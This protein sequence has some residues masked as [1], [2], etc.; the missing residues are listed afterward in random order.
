MGGCVTNS[1]D[2]LDLELSYRDLAEVLPSMV[3]VSRPD[4]WLVYMNEHW[5]AYTGLTLRELNADRAQIFH[6]DDAERVIAANAAARERGEPF[7]IDY[8]VR[9]HDGVYRWHTW[10][11]VPFRD[12]AGDISHWAGATIDID[13]RRRSEQRLRESEMRWLSLAETMPANVTL[14]DP[15]GRM[16]YINQ[17]W[18]DFMGIHEMR[19]ATREW[20]LRL[21]PE[22]RE[23]M[24]GDFIKAV[25][26]NQP[27]EGETRVRGADG[28]YRWF[29]GRTAPVFSDDGDVIWWIGVSVDISERRAHEEQAHARELEYR[30]LADATPAIVCRATADGTLDYFNSQWYAYTGMTP[31]GAV[32]AR[33]IFH[34]DEAD[35]VAGQWWDAIRTGEPYDIE[36]RVRR[37][38]GMYRWHFGRVVPIRDAA[39]GIVNWLSS[40]V[41]IDERKRAED[42]QRVLNEI[43]GALSRSLNYEATLDAIVR[44]SAP[45]FA[46][47]CAVYMGDDAGTI[48]RIATGYGDPKRAGL[49]RHELNAA[50]RLGAASVISTGAVQF[51]ERIPDEV[52]RDAATSDE[53]LA[54]LR[55]VG[56]RSGIVVPV[57]ARGSII[58][59][60]SFSTAESCR[61]YDWNDVELA[62]E[63]GRRAG[64]AIDNA[65]LY[66][67]AQVTLAE[68]RHAN[69][70]KDEFLGLVSHELKTPITTILGNA[71][72]LH[73]KRDRISEGDQ[74]MALADIAHEAERLH[75]II[76]NLL[77]LARLERGQHIEME[78]LLIER[79]V[80]R[81]VRDHMRTNPARKI[82]IT[83]DAANAPALA[84][85]GYSE[86]VLRNL[87]S[88]AE[89][90]SPRDQP[91]DVAITLSGPTIKI[92]VRDRGEGL[93]ADEAE[94]IF[95]P[96]YRSPRVADRAQGVGIGLSVCRRLVEA[97][98]GRIAAGPA[99][100]G[101][102]EFWFT[103]PLGEDHPAV[104]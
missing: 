40:S 92:S 58:G 27:F 36:Y 35:F 90:Y 55:A 28:V 91:I 13:D 14:A 79:F 38:D 103:L 29:L 88:N 73:D 75:S 44:A 63:I 3:A 104:E 68:L 70:A 19:E 42:G 85:A 77:V 39:G 21:H 93:D 97:Q 4:G 96:F 89:K 43:G 51:W 71:K 60:M 69:D 65:R 48:S 86:Q 1:T 10:R 101:G 56:S 87:L 16:Q 11:C 5:R 62:V 7:E 45:R 22:D 80:E 102:T 53:H 34:P 9:R 84:E 76:E 30:S 25:S 2:L 100:G 49:V 15:T 50:G 72:V 57:V 94:R 52:L 47:F 33:D 26:A 59:A 74:H 12:A 54:A 66:R 83:S 98:S 8:R 17:R 41:D 78:P 18:R 99:T 64:L 82:T 31:G 24:V 46:D 81:V 67:D 6:P 20:P 32:N 37:H 95:E 61:T 23:R